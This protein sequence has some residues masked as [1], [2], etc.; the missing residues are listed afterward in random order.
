M[1]CLGLFE[2]WFR[3]GLP[4]HVFELI[5]V[6]D[7]RFKFCRED[8][9]PEDVVWG[10]NT[11]TPDEWEVWATIQMPYLGELLTCPI[12]FSWHLSFWVSFFVAL[13]TGNWWIIPAAIAT[14]PVTL[15]LAHN[16]ISKVN[17]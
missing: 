2:A 17:K 16:L 6:V 5:K 15:N 11:W 1:F 12:C 4:A 8:F 14:F 10:S 13:V 7:D 9:W 3:T